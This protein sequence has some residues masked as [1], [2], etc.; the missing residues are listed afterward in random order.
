M[1][2]IHSQ[3]WRT[4]KT[5]ANGTEISLESCQKTYKNGSISNMQTIQQK[6]PESLGGTS[7]KNNENAH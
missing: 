7:D 5:T 6:T 1:L 3:N 2:S 4:C